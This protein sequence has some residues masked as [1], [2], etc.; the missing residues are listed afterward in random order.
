M[1]G[2]FNVTLSKE[3][4][5]GEKSYTPLAG[6]IK[7]LCA[8]EKLIDV[9]K[10]RHPDTKQ[11]TWRH[12]P[13]ENSPRSRIDYLLCQESLLTKIAET[14]CEEAIKTD[15]RL[16]SIS[17]AGLGVKKQ[18]KGPW[19]LNVSHLKDPKFVKMINEEIE[20]LINIIG[21]DART[22]L[23][24]LKCCLRG[25]II[26]YGARE[27]KKRSQKKK[28][29]LLKSKEAEILNNEKQSQGYMR[30]YEQIVEKETH[31]VLHYLEIDEL[32][33]K[34]N[35]RLIRMGRKKASSKEIEVLKLE[36]GRLVT[37]QTELMEAERA[38]YEKLYTSD[39][40]VT[41]KFNTNKRKNDKHIENGEATFSLIEIGK[42]LKELHNGKAPGGDGYP[43]EFY[44]MFWAKVGNLTCEA[45][46]ES[47][48]KGEMSMDQ[49][50]AMIKIIPKE[51]KDLLDLGNWRPISLLNA[52]YKIFAKAIANRM[53]K[54]VERVVKHDQNAYIKGRSIRS[55][56][57]AMLD[58]IQHCHEN[59]VTSLLC[60]IDFSKAFDN[61]EHKFILDTLEH[62]NFPTEEI[63]MVKVAYAN[64]ESSVVMNGEISRSFKVT[65]SIRQGCPLSTLL[66][67]LAV[68]RLAD[69]IRDDPTI[70]GVRIG[71][72]TYKVSQLAD[73]TTLFL[74]DKR[75]LSQCMKILTKFRKAAGLKI[76]NKKSE[77]L[78]LGGL[79]IPAETIQ[80]PQVEKLTCLG[81]AL[82]KSW[83][84]TV[85]ANY[86]K[87][88]EKVKSQIQ[89]WEKLYPDLQERIYLIKCKIIPTVTYTLS[90]LPLDKNNISIIEE[91][92]QK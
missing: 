71:T 72:E 39:P 13:G 79:D 85:K 86:E 67:V 89:F 21:G 19:K 38:F 62:Y 63:N 1:G 33:E 40:L 37:N 36:S 52:H 6:E 56:L 24:T 80:L 20:E 90:N 54:R 76:N 73:D 59:D 4:L 51:G 81:L 82:T 15:H 35:E 49:K 44:K 28:E 78:C 66:F 47:I 46:N 5:Y 74:K 91:S 18:C 32:G 58:I 2:D 65:R 83:P 84:G 42:A 8:E 77:I 61:L 27:K 29:L 43:P 92:R 60:C 25:K 14:D 10:L 7:K 30:E 57:R 48:E 68:E 55:N 70:Q 23:D 69:R 64:I 3:D 34:P 87:S 11:Y 50:K 22:K 9:W 41:S 75:D 26:A 12:G 16:V 45:I 31:S 17:I 88:L 53:M